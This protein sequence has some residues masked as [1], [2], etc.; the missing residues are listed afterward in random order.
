[1]GKSNQY[2]TEEKEKQDNQIWNEKEDNHYKEQVIDKYS[3]ILE[4]EK[5]DNRLRYED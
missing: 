5:Y 4:D 2:F 1:M 3:K